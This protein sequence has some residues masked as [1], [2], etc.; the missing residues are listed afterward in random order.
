MIL[1]ALKEYYDRKATDPNSGIAPEGWEWKEIPYIVVLNKDGEPVDIQSTVEGTGKTKTTKSFLLPQSRVR[2]VGIAANL[3]W[4]SP[5]YALGVVL[6]GKPDRVAQQHE[7]FKNELQKIENCHDL[8]FVALKKFLDLHDKLERLEIFDQWASLVKEGKFLVFKLAGE[9]GIL[10]DSPLLRQAISNLTSHSTAGDSLC[11]ITG[12]K[13]EM[14]RTHAKIK[15]VWGANT[16]GGAIIGFNH[17]AFCS[18]NK[19]QGDNAPVGKRAASAFATALNTMLAK[20]SKNRMQV[21]DASTVFWASKPTDFE[22][23]FGAMFAEPSKDNPDEGVAAVRAL[24]TSIENG[25]YH[26]IADPTRFYVLGLAPNAARISVRFFDVATI[27]EMAVRIRQHFVDT[28]IQKQFPKEPEYLSL[29]RLLICTAVQGKSENI[30]PNLAGETMRAILEG[31]PY[32]VTLMNAV[33]RRIRAEHEISYPRAALLKGYL[34]RSSHSHKEIQE[35]LDTTN[36]NIGYLLGRLFATL[37]KIQTDASPGLNATIRDRFYGAASG[38]PAVVFPNLMRLKNHHLSKLDNTRLRIW[39]EQLL[40]E[41]IGGIP[42]E[43]P[44]FLSLDDQGRFAIGYYHQMQSFYT[45]KNESPKETNDC[46][47]NAPLFS[48]HKELNH[49]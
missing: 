38:T 49:V 31:T 25:A 12:E 24:F 17:K 40:G 8:G 23:C 22:D 5:E 15:G 26:E 43:F 16:T 48:S 42:G 9:Q 33:I 37:E 39:F 20:G 13:D 3:C 41:I 44:K 19:E 6:K 11:L 10:T 4:D 47:R 14:E 32:P 45:K 2:T 36:H 27:E 1:Q 35:M 46:E 21:G 29:F 30:P 18:F 28:K 7:A 34:N